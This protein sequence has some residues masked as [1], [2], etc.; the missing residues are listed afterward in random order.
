M[1][2]KQVSQTIPVKGMTCAACAAT[3]EKVLLKEEGVEKAEVNYATNSVKIQTKAEANLSKLKK[4]VNKAG[5]DL[6]IDANGR[7]V[8]GD[9]DL[10]KLKNHLW[11]AIPLTLVVVIL[12]MF[13]E[14]FAFKNSVLLVLSIPVLFWSGLRFYASALR[15][16]SRGSMNMD[17]LIASGTGAAFFFSLY[18]TFFPESLVDQNLEAHV[19]YESAAVIITF[20]LL[21]KF[22]EEKAKKSTSSAIEKLYDLNVQSVVRLVNGEQDLIQIEEVVHGDILLI[23]AGDRIPV[24]GKIVFGASTVDESMLSGE[25]IPVEKSVGD[26]L[27]A[28]TLN[29]NGTVQMSAEKVGTETILGQIIKVVS[30]AMGSKAPAQKLA[31]RIASVFVPAVLVLALATF[32]TWYFFVPQ[33]SLAIAFIN[34]F[35]VLIIACPCALGLAT[36]TAIMVGIGK[37]ASNGVLIKDAAALEKAKGLQKLFLDKTGTIS[38][39]ELEVTEFE[40]YFG[41]EERLELFSILNGM[42]SSSSHPIAKSIVEHLNSNYNLFPFLMNKVETLP[43]IGLKAIVDG[44]SYEVAGNDKSK[45]SYFDKVQQTQIEEFKKKGLSLVFFWKETTLLA[46]F[47][48]KDSLKSESREVVENLMNKGISLEILSGDHEEAVSAVAYEVGIDKYHFGLL[49]NDKTN[50][51]REAKNEMTVGF[52]GDGINDAPALAIADL[53]IAM[54]TGTDIAMESADVT[55]VSGDLGKID[56]LIRFSKQTVRTMHQNLF[57][58]FFYNLIAIPIAAGVLIPINGFMLNPMVAGAAMAF[59]SLSV[60]L[61]SLRLKTIK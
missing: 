61:N 27:R 36:P 16:L 9:E 33:G 20:I 46:I 14:D 10:Q 2:T 5:Y 50:I 23:K 6:L 3:I 8:N 12:S 4:V 30:E 34:T 32:L 45:Y 26:E 51:V 25:A 48:L 60:V 52:A 28:G 47:G 1:D 19:Y 24:D 56:Q 21:G 29:Q 18:V 17:T 43:G 49:P 7:S 54:S 22:L 53:S 11:M 44:V 31:D 39:G 37:A 41:E 38:K 57:W 55:L 59:S 42:E 58:A 35:N 40:I 15:Q 13:V